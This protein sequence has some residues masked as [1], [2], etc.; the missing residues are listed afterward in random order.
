MGLESIELLVRIEEVFNIE[1]LEQEA[2]KIKTVGD[3]TVCIERKVEFQK[4][5]HSVQKEMHLIFQNA[6]TDLQLKDIHLYALINT[7][8]TPNELDKLWHYIKKHSKLHLPKIKNKTLLSKK[9][10][11]IQVCNL[12][13]IINWTIALNHQT[14]INPKALNSSYEIESILN[15]ILINQFHVPYLQI[16]PQAHLIND[17]GLD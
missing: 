8:L 9:D 13:Q 14:L 7:L 5:R 3:M 11:L 2:C 12:N 1:I 17:L 4:K 10:T 6:W 15:G 16:N